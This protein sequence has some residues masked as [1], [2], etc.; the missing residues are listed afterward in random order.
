MI[1]PTYEI[2]DNSPIIVIADVHGQYDKLISL[3]NK[4]PE[5]AII[6]FVGDL[7]DRGYNNR[8]C[9][10]F[11]KNY[12]SVIGNHEEMMIE[13][14]EEFKFEKGNFSNSHDWIK[15]G[16]RLTFL[17]YNS[18]DEINYDLD[19]LKSLPFAIR[20]TFPDKK[21][22]IVSHS[23]I[24]PLINKNGLL[25][26]NEQLNIYGNDFDDIKNYVLW[27]RFHR[28]YTDLHPKTC[29]IFGHTITDFDDFFINSE[30]AVIDN[31]AFDIGKLI[32]LSYP[33]FKIYTS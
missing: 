13:Y 20:F 12:F 1:I 17:E 14:F 21:D 23:D 28:K 18:E 32:G 19:Y 9:L 30:K 8:R 33:D 26:L 29:F 2:S 16:G 24:S 3:I 6:C 31:G 27:N 5:N 11:S 4:I 7:I 10:D 22:L 15:Y 25:D